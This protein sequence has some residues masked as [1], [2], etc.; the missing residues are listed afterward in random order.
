MYEPLPSTEP[1]GT[2]F[3]G[4]AKDISDKVS[5]ELGNAKDWINNKRII[6]GT[7]L[8]DHLKT[9]TTKESLKKIAINTAIGTAAGALTNI[10]LPGSGVVGGAAAGGL[11]AGA[12]EYL[13]ERGKV[14]GGITM[15]RFDTGG[16]SKVEIMRENLRVQ[17]KKEMKAFQLT[18][19][20][21]IGKAVL[22]GAI[23]GAAG[24]FIGGKIIEAFQGHEV[25]LSSINQAVKET[26]K[27]NVSNP[28]EVIAKAKPAIIPLKDN[29][30]HTMR[31]YLDSKLQVHG[32]PPVHV[33]NTEVQKVVLAAIK[34]NKIAHPSALAKN[35]QI[36]IGNEQ[37]AKTVD[38]IIKTRKL[39]ASGK[40][41]LAG[42]YH[43]IIEIARQHLPKGTSP[44]KIKAYVTEICKTNKINSGYAGVDVKG[45]MNA[46]TLAPDTVIELP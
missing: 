14:M 39:L 36:Q 34:D 8:A 1:L 10:A 38:N 19:K 43:S 5:L 13:K 24:R 9:I 28:I 7:S 4:T 3:R 26:F 29:L 20:K 40:G 27:T 33:S 15:D 32:G 16:K 23:A 22:N 25:P 45:Y 30:W 18:D 17:I 42:K 41:V 11:A 35:T 6:L 44:D 46:N 37:V 12:R 31:G 2:K 21:V